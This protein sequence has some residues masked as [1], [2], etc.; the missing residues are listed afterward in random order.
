MLPGLEHCLFPEWGDLL[1]LHFTL[2]RFHGKINL[3]GI[4]QFLPPLCH[5][6]LPE[7][8]YSL[9]DIVLN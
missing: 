4:F 7:S 2:S 1:N 8:P 5:K 9:L 6:L 3:E